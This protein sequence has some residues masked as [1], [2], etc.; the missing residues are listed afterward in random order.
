MNEQPL[1]DDDFRR[2]LYPSLD[3]SYHDILKKIYIP[4]PENWGFLDRPVILL[5][6]KSAYGVFGKSSEGYFLMKILFASGLVTLLVCFGI[7]FVDRSESGN[8]KI[9]LI[10]FLACFFL[11]SSSP[12]FMSMLWLCDMEI[13]AQL[14]LVMCL[15]LY[16]HL[17][18]SK[19]ALQ[20]LHYKSIMFQV[21]IFLIA[22]LGYKTKSSVK[23][24]P[25]VM[26]LHL[27]WDQRRSVKYYI[28]LITSLI[29][30]TIPLGHLAK[31]PI[32]KFLSLGGAYSGD[33][34][35]KWQPIN[36][37]SL[38]RM[39]LGNTESLWLLETIKSEPYGLIQ[40]LFP[41]GLFG[42]LCGTVFIIIKC[43]HKGDNSFNK[44]I[45]VWLF[46]C[47]LLFPI[48]PIVPDWLTS[49]YL[50]PTFL[51]MALI[52]LSTAYHLFSK[53][54]YRKLGIIFTLFV[55]LHVLAGSYQIYFQKTTS[56]YSLIIKDRF[57]EY[58]ENNIRDS[59]IVLI[60]MP[61]YNYF[62]SNNNNLYHAVR[63]DS[64]SEKEKY[65]KFIM[66]EQSLY[67]AVGNDNL[68][69]PYLEKKEI[70]IDKSIY[71][72]LLGQHDHVS[73][74]FIYKMQ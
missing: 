56:G 72:N 27:L 70:S 49:R 5:F 24:L 7:A 53:I 73:N 55:A 74:I 25:I 17:R 39:L 46:C 20:P 1:F 12:I 41:F 71:F 62:K 18:S 22:L 28:P 21:A 4:F 61:Q 50:V 6:F 48:Y 69:I 2:W 63:D 44:L 42:V 65:Q 26:L 35:W 36:S 16:M 13:L 64:Q 8:K 10:A 43:F 3:M 19:L 57:Y 29:L 67:L 45:I 34:L 23:I 60:G 54:K 32:P 68:G 33:F 52:L 58:I 15:L 11:L 51:P 9:F 66:A 38:T 47:L 37:Y 40:V 14:F 31:S 30:I 59:R